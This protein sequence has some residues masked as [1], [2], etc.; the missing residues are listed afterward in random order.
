MSSSWY[1]IPIHTVYNYRIRQ[2]AVA[3]CL[4]VMLL[5][6]WG[7]PRTAQAITIL[8]EATDLAPP[9]PGGGDLWQ[10]TYHVSGFTPQINTAFEMLFDPTLYRDLQDPPPAVTD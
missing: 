2:G 4:A 1:A 7:G 6:S 8:F 9:G 3:L 10:Y 5:A